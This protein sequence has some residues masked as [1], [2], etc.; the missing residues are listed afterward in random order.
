MR[1]N[2]NI[3]NISSSH[4]TLEVVKFVYRPDENN[5]FRYFDRPNELLIYHEPELFKL[6]T[7]GYS[8]IRLKRKNCDVVK[9]AYYD[10]YG[11]IIIRYTRRKS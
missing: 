9:T 4:Q 8:N 7:L 2:F 3:M 11:N 10:K 5:I 6:L 1:S